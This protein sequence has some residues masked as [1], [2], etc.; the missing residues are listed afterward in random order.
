[1]ERFKERM[2]QYYLNKCVNK[3]PIFWSDKLANKE[4]KDN[5]QNIAVKV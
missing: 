1:M 5:S 3:K 2:K 4:K